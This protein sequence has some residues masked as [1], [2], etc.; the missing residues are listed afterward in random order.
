MECLETDHM[1]AASTIANS[2]KLRDGA[3]PTRQINMNFLNS[4]YII[5]KISLILI[6]EVVITYGQ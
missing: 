5:N 3:S 2:K 6:E 1:N 4:W